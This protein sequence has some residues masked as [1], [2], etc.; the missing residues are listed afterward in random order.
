[1]LCFEQHCLFCFTT[2]SWRL[3]RSVVFLPWVK[4][5]TW[6][7]WSH[8]M[9]LGYYWWQDVSLCRISWI[10]VEFLKLKWW[11]P[12]MVV[13]VCV[14]VFWPDPTAT[15][16][17]TICWTF[18]QPT[19][20]AIPPNVDF[21]L[22]NLW[23]ITQYRGWDQCAYCWFWN[24]RVCVRP[25]NLSNVT[26]TRLKEQWAFILPNITHGWRSFLS[27]PDPVLSLPVSLHYNHI[28]LKSS[29]NML[30]DYQ[31]VPCYLTAV[32][33]VL[34]VHSIIN[35]IYLLKNSHSQCLQESSMIS[36]LKL[37]V[38]MGR[39][40]TWAESFA[41]LWLPLI[42]PIGFVSYDINHVFPQLVFI[43]IYLK[44]IYF[45]IIYLIT[46]TV[47]LVLS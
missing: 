27:F 37:N 35:L 14:C 13:L 9:M 47:N 36:Y 41:N 22:H 31:S 34:R 33:A 6:P 42:P 2:V 38:V 46:F 24:S 30:Y 45:Y 18:Y 15:L 12:V 21:T 26:Q 10:P 17:S 43:L 29:V 1:M 39:S 3:R 19:V 20:C 23:T 40:L 4:K 8:K 25:M 16:E 7:Y 11:F 32:P 5:Y 44:K 28:I